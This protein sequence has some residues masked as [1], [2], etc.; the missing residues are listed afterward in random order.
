MLQNDT[1]STFSMMGTSTLYVDPM[2]ATPSSVSTVNDSFTTLRSCQTSYHKKS[3]IDC[4]LQTVGPRFLGTMIRWNLPLCSRFYISKC[5]CLTPACITIVAE[6]ACRIPF[7]SNHLPFR[8][9]ASLLRLSTKYQ[10]NTVCDALLANLQT[11]YAP[12]QGT[13]GAFPVHHQCFGDPR[14]HPNDVLKLFYE[15]R[16]EFALP[17]ALYEACVAGI[18]SLTNTD[19]SIKLSPVLLSQAVRGFYT[20]QEWE[21]RLARGILFLDRQ[22]HTSN[23]C[24]PL[25]LRSTNSGSPLQD[26]LCAVRPGFGV[27]TGGIFHIPDFPN[28]DNCMDCVR[29]WNDIKQ[30]AKVELWKFLP[31][32]FGMESWTEICS[33]SNRAT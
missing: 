17:L 20:L 14:P 31:E 28:G 29:G 21:W 6:L 7:G 18:R 23:K 15:C 11:T 5:G 8:E 32:I 30:Q 1:Q 19:P 22:S 13:G 12:S 25:D 9:F 4:P 27:T 16:V 10:I 2:V 24:R 3:F 26:V 33:K